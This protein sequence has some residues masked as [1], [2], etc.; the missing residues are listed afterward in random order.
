[1]SWQ[2]IL[3]FV[4]MMRWDLLFNTSSLTLA[5][6]ERLWFVIQ[7]RIIIHPN[8]VNQ[9]GLRRIR[10]GFVWSTSPSIL[11][12]THLRTNRLAYSAVVLSITRLNILFWSICHILITICPVNKRL[13]VKEAV[14]LLRKFLIVFRIIMLVVR[15]ILL[16]GR[17]L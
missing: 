8:L 5:R 13:I 2:I 15:K 10:L 1:M 4:S 9:V 17:I 3:N 11:L 14:L 7:S 16:V 12:F 6:N